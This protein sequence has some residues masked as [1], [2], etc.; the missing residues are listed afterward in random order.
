MSR[1]LTERYL[2]ELVEPCGALPRK[3]LFIYLDEFWGRADLD[4]NEELERWSSAA[5]G[6][7][8]SPPARSSTGNVQSSVGGVL[9]SAE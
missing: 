8:D 1:L 7:G 4:A 9:H 3:C 6:S 2:T 5:T